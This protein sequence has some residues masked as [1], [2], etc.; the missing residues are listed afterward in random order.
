[1][2]SACVVLLES[3]CD[4]VVEDEAAD[5]EDEVAVVLELEGNAATNQSQVKQLQK[6]LQEEEA[7]E[8]AEDFDWSERAA[9]VSDG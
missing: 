7:V 9:E 1:M 6:V 5:G 8:E 4:V 3:I 2:V